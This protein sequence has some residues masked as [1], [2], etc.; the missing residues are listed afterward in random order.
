MQ[1]FEL[2]WH[3]RLS[4]KPWTVGDILFDYKVEFIPF[5]K[6]EAFSQTSYKQEECGM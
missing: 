5:A 2:E 1:S 6:S 4:T 3:V